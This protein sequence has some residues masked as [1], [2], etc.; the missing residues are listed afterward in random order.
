[1][2]KLLFTVFLGM[3]AVSSYS[4]FSVGAKAG[5]VVSTFSGVKTETKAAVGYKAGLSAQY[6][7]SRWGVQS[8]FYL[9]EAGLAY[10][11]GLW[12]NRN[13]GMNLINLNFALK[14][15]EIPLSVVYKYPIDNRLKLTFNAGGYFAFK[16]SGNGTIRY[17][18]GAISVD[19]FQ[20]IQIVGNPHLMDMYG[21][22]ASHE[23]WGLA[24]GAGVDIGNFNIGVNYNQGLTSVFRQYNPLDEKPA[25]A[26]N[27]IVWIALGYSF[28]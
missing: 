4:Q 9:S 28:N 26:K 21:E 17:D 14:Y 22:Q 10:S 20:G 3:I 16:H 8:G 23:D 1:M 5:M 25:N 7:F 24:L 13:D 6:L 11:E 2:K 15:F 12:P 27:R 19:P 18:N